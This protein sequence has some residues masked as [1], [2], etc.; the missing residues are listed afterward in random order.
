[1]VGCTVPAPEPEPVSPI[2]C[3]GYYKLYDHYWGARLIKEAGTY[4]INPDERVFR[5]GEPVYNPVAVF[6]ECPT[7]YEK[8]LIYE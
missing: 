1:L 7:E 3:D 2:D 4:W 6:G 5:I 8:E